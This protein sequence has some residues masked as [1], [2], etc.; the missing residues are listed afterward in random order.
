[1]LLLPQA[2][3]AVAVIEYFCRRLVEYSLVPDNGK[4]T[5]VASKVYAINMYNKKEYR[6]HFNLY[7]EFIDFISSKV[8]YKV[9][10][11]VPV[12]GVDVVL[13][14][15]EKWKLLERQI[16]F[17]EYAIHTPELW[18][19]PNRILTCQPGAGKTFILMKTMSEYHKRTIIIMRP[20]YMFNFEAELWDTYDILPEKAITIAGGEQLINFL[21][22]VKNNTLDKD[23]IMISNKT[24]YGYLQAHISCSKEALLE[25]Y[26]ISID[27]LF[28][29]GNFG[30]RAID[31]VHQ[32]FHF[33]HRLDLFTNVRKSLSL[34]AT[35]VPN[36]DHFLSYIQN[37]TYPVNDRF[38]Q[39]NLN[40]YVNA[41]AMF[42][43]LESPYKAKYTNGSF[44][45]HNTYEKYLLTNKKVLNNYMTYIKTCIDFLYIKNK[46]SNEKFLVFVSSGN[47]GK[48]MQIKLQSLYPDLI[49]GRYIRKFNDKKDVLID[50][51]IIVS[52]LQS[53]G[54][55]VTVPN[56]GGV[57]LSHAIDSEASNLQGFGRIRDLNNNVEHRFG[58]SV[59][60]DIRSQ[61]SYHKSKKEYLLSRVNH[62]QE[63]QTRIYV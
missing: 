24:F 32:D 16:P 15:F 7:K 10:D 23:I 27:D 49:V 13:P 50:S 30:F 5:S 61:V 44:Y 37:V 25:K 46:K 48:Y 54:T 47:M 9:Y 12:D 53:C 4:L 11:D 42:Y 3:T 21:E 60:H 45:S 26:K 43:N 6:I 62:L 39:K 55:A 52:T 14:M 56:L 35:L 31:E 63:I 29:L 18:E 20:T 2:D 36:K 57:F 28:A 19:N 51:D 58:Y 17:Y 1:M 22:S 8:T 38:V 33:N 41:Y 40:V 34:S 59:C